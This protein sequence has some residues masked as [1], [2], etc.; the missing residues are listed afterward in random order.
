[1]QQRL[2]PLKIVRER[3]DYPQVNLVENGIQIIELNRGCK[4]GCSFCYADPNYKVFDVPEIIS[5]KVR[6]RGEGFLYDPKIKEKIIEL[7]NKRVNNKVVYYELNQ[8]IDFRLL[9]KE[10]AELLSKYRFGLINK[11]GN[12]YK[13]IKFAWDGGKNHEKLTKET[14][15]LFESVGYKRK[16]IMIFV[17]INWKIDY[18]TCLYKLDKFKFKQWNVQIDPCTWDTTKSEKL[19][20]H[21]SKK[22][23]R[24]FLRKAR[25]HNQIIRHDG[26]D[27]EVKST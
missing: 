8:G 18:E 21:W 10:I 27:P 6:I 24:D 22:Q 5:N 26:Y 16:S 9:T 13:S 14:I 17:L 3:E 23:L 4:R 19:P 15:E 1:M 11:K 12:W 7:G 2:I 20:L 25:K